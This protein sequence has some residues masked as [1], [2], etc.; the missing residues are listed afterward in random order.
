MMSPSHAAAVAVLALSSVTSGTA[1][2]ASAREDKTLDGKLVA[3]NLDQVS[4]I[5]GP[6][7]PAAS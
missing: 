6:T 3:G 5:I 2:A 7:P 4:L 1:L